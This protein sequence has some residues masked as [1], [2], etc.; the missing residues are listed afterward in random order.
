MP[1]LPRH[2]VTRIVLLGDAQSRECV[3]HDAQAGITRVD[4]VDTAEGVELDR[5]LELEE[6]VPNA[7]RQE[8][9]GARKVDERVDK[10]SP[11]GHCLVVHVDLLRGVGPAAAR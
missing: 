11:A 10:S 7:F 9:G 3:Q 6:F 5:P 8:F 4:R 2:R 1:S